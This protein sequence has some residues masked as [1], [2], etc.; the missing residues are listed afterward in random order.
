MCRVKDFVTLHPEWDVSINS[1]PSQLMEPF[2]RGSKKI[3]RARGD[4]KHQG[5]KV[6]ESQQD[7]CAYELTETVAVYTRSAAQDWT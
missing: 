4:G 7:Q 3:V 5:N 6:S 2:G 1:L